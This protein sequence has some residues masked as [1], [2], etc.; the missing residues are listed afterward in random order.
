MKRLFMLLAKIKHHFKVDARLEHIYDKSANA[1][2]L[3]LRTGKIPD[4]Q[5]REY[6]I[7]Y[8]LSM[9]EKIPQGMM[10]LDNHPGFEKMAK[11]VEEELGLEAVQP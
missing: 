5:D 2:K 11:Q 3:T 8:V 7:E 6:A 4:R 1:I 9:R 10:Y